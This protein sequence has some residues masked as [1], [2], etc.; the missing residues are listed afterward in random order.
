MCEKKP[1]EQDL[2]LVLGYKDLSWSLKLIVIYQYILMIISTI[3]FL[4]GFMNGI[5]S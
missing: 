3:Y 2:P 4:I 5:M 1:D